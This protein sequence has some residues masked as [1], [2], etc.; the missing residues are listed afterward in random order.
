MHPDGTLLKSSDQP[1]VWLIQGGERHWIPSPE[2]FNAHGFSWAAIL[3]VSDAEINAI[4]QGP[5]VPLYTTWATPGPNDDVIPGAPS[6]P[7]AEYNGVDYRRWRS[8]NGGHTIYA[9]GRFV[10]QR[11]SF[12][13]AT[14]TSNSVIFAGYHSGTA[15]VVTGVDGHVLWSS[16]LFRVGVNPQ[17]FSGHPQVSVNT[18]DYQVPMDI[19]D[20]AGGISLVI[21][22]SPDNL[23]DILNHSVGAL[24]SSLAPAIS[25]IGGL[26]S[27][28][29][30]SSAQAQPAAQVQHTTQSAA[31]RKRAWTMLPH[32]NG[33]VAAHAPAHPPEH[34]AV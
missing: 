6:L 15:A 31:A 5:D 32:Q 33:D 30:K 17:G 18:W 14:V 12:Q 8:P 28:S 21:T 19:A 1:E 4:P 34:A 27:G 22:D 2:I 3:V 13:G 10:V 7:I 29:K 20:Q 23:Q 26:F 24:I 9:N 25:A 16:P 11:G